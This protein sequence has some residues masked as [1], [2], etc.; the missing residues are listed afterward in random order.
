MKALRVL[1]TVKSHPTLMMHA[2]IIDLFKLWSKYVLRT[3][4]SYS[5]L[6]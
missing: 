5:S 6:D 3:Q 2:N 4:R 1:V